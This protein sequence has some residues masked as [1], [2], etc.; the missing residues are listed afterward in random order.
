MLRNPQEIEKRQ[1]EIYEQLFL[2]NG[3]AMIQLTKWVSLP[4]SILSH[5]RR[6]STGNPIHSRYLLRRVLL[7]E[8]HEGR[9]YSFSYSRTRAKDG[10]IV[11]D[12]DSCNV[13]STRTGVSQRAR[14]IVDDCGAMEFQTAKHHPGRVQGL[15]PR[16][17][18]E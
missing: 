6:V 8:N 16:N 13:V 1:D 11:F 7:V 17:V 5:C 9:V 18:D 4:M 2:S 12:C 15:R 14:A 10:K 3:Q